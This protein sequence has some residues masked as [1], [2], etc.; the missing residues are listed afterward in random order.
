MLNEHSKTT[1][2]LVHTAKQPVAHKPWARLA[3]AAL[4]LALTT[5]TAAAMKIQTITS[6]GGIEA[7]F[8]EEHGLPLLSMQY[9]FK[10]GTAQDPE[11]KPGVAHFITTMMNEGAGDMDARAFQQRE[12][13]LAMRMSFDAGRDEFTGSFQSLT[14]NLDASADMLR[15]A[16]TKTRFDTDAVL[17]MRKELTASLAFDAK[18]PEKIAGNAWYAEAYAGHPYGWPA[19]GTAESMAKITSDDL[20]E[21]RRRVFT[22]DALKI[23]VVGDIEPEKLGKLLDKIFGDLPAKGDLKPVARIEP[24]VGPKLTMIEMDVPQSVATF[25]RIGLDRKDPDF[26]AGFIVNY[27][28]GGGGLTSRLTDEVREKNG[29]AYSVYSYMM[30]YDQSSVFAGGVATKTS[31]IAKS[32]EIIKR[33]LAKMATD[34][35]TA[36]EL[37]DAKQYLTGSY[38][39]RFDSSNKIASQLLGIQMDELGIDYIDKRNALVD[40]VTMED[41]KRV[42]KRMVSPDNLLITV[43]GQKGAL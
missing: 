21:F 3:A 8:V 17:R 28:V 1:T 43:V 39:L 6:P 42:A 11:D 19:N 14:Q 16:L 20:Q 26:I 30:T 23:S 5:G 7:W 29:L 31:G 36:E 13:E 33:E 27:I 38:A 10:G 32:L 37:Q 15:L 9:G 12:E 4:A 41:V 25:G 22:R 40:G 2:T 24:K 18:D 34:G 35:P